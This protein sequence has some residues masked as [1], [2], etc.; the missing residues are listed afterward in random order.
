[1][2]R[3][4][5][6]NKEQEDRKMP[7]VVVGNTAD[8]KKESSSKKMRTDVGDEGCGGAAA[9]AEK[10]ESATSISQ[11]GKSKNSST[12]TVIKSVLT[13]VFG[14]E[15]ATC[16]SKISLYVESLIRLDVLDWVENKAETDTCEDVATKI[17]G[18]LRTY[19]D[20]E[21]FNEAAIRK[22]SELLRHEDEDG[23]YSYGEGTMDWKMTGQ[24]YRSDG[25]NLVLERMIMFPSNAAIQ[26][27]AC[28]FFGR[29]P[30]NMRVTGEEFVLE[31]DREHNSILNFLVSPRTIGAMARAI[32]THKDNKRVVG[33]AM[34][35]MDNLE[36]VIVA[37]GTRPVRHSAFHAQVAPAMAQ[38]VQ[39]MYQSNM[40]Q[41]CLTALKELQED[42]TVV[43]S[44]ISLLKHMKTSRGGGAAF[45]S[46]LRNNPDF[47]EVIQQAQETQK[48]V[49][50]DDIYIDREVYFLRMPGR[51]E[52]VVS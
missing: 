14:D 37:M 38:L 6:N 16:S 4:M 22:L 15:D 42:Y 41:L 20:D 26:E 19:R 8:G 44:A 17:C 7:A 23:S 3:N 11:L 12:T 28:L 21:S 25:H 39:S 45:Q 5:D 40:P 48:E 1:M 2:D 50:P 9:G 13:Q 34:E 24:V 33:I 43:V 36:Q 31:G 10:Q 47:W 27:H 18:Y 32:E 51:D 30:R 52:C 35:I 29:F 46:F 49:T